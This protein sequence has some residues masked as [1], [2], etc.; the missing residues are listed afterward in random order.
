MGAPPMADPTR[1]FYSSLL[2]EN[3]DSKIAIRWCVEYGVLSIEEH[4]K[5]FK[6]FAKL[7][8]AGAYNIA[9]QIKRALEKSEKKKEKKD[10]KDKKEKKAKRKRKKKRKFATTVN[11]SK[12]AKSFSHHQWLI[13]RVP[14]TRRC[15]Q[16]TPTAK[17]R[18]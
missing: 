16:R 14:F 12:R 15:W 13:Q 4:K 8:D 5:V 6:R 7:R 18:S 10:K 2:A 11:Y 3:P 9:T 17:L 1:A